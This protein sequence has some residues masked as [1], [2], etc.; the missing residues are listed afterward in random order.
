MINKIT[1]K[2]L[3]KGFYG[4]SIDSKSVKKGNL[5][6]AIKGRNNDGHNY[7]KEAILK[8]ASYCVISKNLNK[9][10]K[11]KVIKAAITYNFLKELAILKRSYSNGKITL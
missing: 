7:L 4:V 10:P 11:N 6:F 5:F 2:K 8:G 1:N 9:I 3:V